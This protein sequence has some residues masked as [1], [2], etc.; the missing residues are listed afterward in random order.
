[1]LSPRSRMPSRNARTAGWVAAVFFLGMGAVALVH[2]S[3]VPRIFGGAAPTRASRTEVRAVYGGFGVGAG[4]LVAHAL[5]ARTAQASGWLQCLGV[6]MASMAAG[7]VAGALLEPGQALFP[8]WAFVAVE[9]A[10]AA[11]LFAAA[12]GPPGLGA[13]RRR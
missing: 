8:T 11:A 6:S 7:R 13:S 9:V 2:P 3:Y 5:R 4:L 10:L 1:L 12:G